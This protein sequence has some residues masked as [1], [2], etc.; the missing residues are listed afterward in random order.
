[1]EV[2]T[3]SCTKQKNWIQGPM[4]SELPSR[5]LAHF[6]LPAVLSTIRGDRPLIRSASTRLDQAILFGCLYALT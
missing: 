1:M 6:G 4:R 2:C 3:P 5:R